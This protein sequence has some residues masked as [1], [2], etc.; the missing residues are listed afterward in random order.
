LKLIIKFCKFKSTGDP[1]WIDTHVLVGQAMAI[2]N[3][4]TQSTSTIRTTTTTT[5]TTTATTVTAAQTLPPATCSNVVTACGDG[6]LYNYVTSVNHTITP[7]SY[8]REQSTVTANTA[9]LC[10]QVCADDEICLSFTYNCNTRQCQLYKA[11]GTL[12]TAE[13]VQNI[14]NHVVTPSSNGY[15]AGSLSP[16]DAPSD[17]RY[18]GEDYLLATTTTL[19]PTEF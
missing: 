12:L 14:A 8:L 17:M 5:T 19:S 1:I 6:G 15:V 13:Q 9:N 18:N 4:F 2:D 11:P 7:G 3:R 10:C 16:I